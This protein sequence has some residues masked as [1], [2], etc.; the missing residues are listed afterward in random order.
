M[1]PWELLLDRFDVRVL[2]T[3]SNLF[4]LDGLGIPVD[5]VRSPRG[6]FP[7]GRAGSAATYL[8]GDRYIGLSHHLRDA[9]IVHSCEI[10][11]W[12]SAQAATAKKDL[13]FKLALTVWETIPWASTWRW[14][15]E[16]RYRRDVM[17]ET[18]L[19]LPTSKRAALALRL[20][21]APAGKIKLCPPGV[22]LQRFANRAAEATAAA[23]SPLILSAGRLVWEKG[24][25]DVLRAAA[26]MAQGFDGE[27]PVDGLRVLIVGDGPEGKR[28]RGYADELGI[29]DRVEFRRSVPYDE[30]PGV[31][32]SASVL[33]L[34][35][36][37][38]QGWEEQ[39]GMVL[40]EAMASGLAVITT[41]S[42]AIPEVVGGPPAI[43][44]PSGD[45]PSLASALR[46]RL[47]RSSSNES[48]SWSAEHLS[49]FSRE[50][51]AERVAQAYWQLLG[52]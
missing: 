37:Q 47:E 20:E 21:G 48:I 24:H 15:R 14:P 22:D 27:L 51:A 4:Q 26:V 30:M 38:R 6:L 43:L 49:Q 12:F 25:Q 7:R 39:F 34:A 35:S 11:T 3:G 28:L 31:Y 46:L 42:G 8:L 32:A 17:A 41:S 10:G 5:H 29:G 45:W 2:V 36:L 16:R 13:G 50:S 33:V 1:R 9:D 19:Y 23:E 52:A 44:F 40:T 18:D